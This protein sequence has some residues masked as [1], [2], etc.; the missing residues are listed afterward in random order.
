M[1]EGAMRDHLAQQLKIHPD[2]EFPLLAYLGEDLP[3]APVDPHDTPL[4]LLSAGPLSCPSR[5]TR[6][7]HRRISPWPAFRSSFP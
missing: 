1:P 2:N 7:I 6:A 4:T 3:G 5:W